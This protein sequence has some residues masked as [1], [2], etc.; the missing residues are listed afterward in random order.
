LIFAAFDNADLMR[1]Y[2]QTGFI[3]A[4]EMVMSRM[5]AD[6]YTKR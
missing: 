6:I 2:D 1:N 3:E 4:W 5:R